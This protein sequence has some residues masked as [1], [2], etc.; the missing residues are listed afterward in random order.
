MPTPTDILSNMKE[1][2]GIAGSAMATG[3]S[4]GEPEVTGELRGAGIAF[5][6]LI[7]ATGEAVANTQRQ[8]NDTSAATATAL[9]QNKVDVIAVQ[10]KIFDDAGTL[11]EVQ[12]HTRKLPLVNFIDPV[13]YEW[14][15]VRLQGT[16]YAREFTSE[17]GSS[18]SSSASSTTSGG[19]G[20]FSIEFGGISK[21]IAAAAL[22]KLAGGSGSSSS[23]PSSSGSSSQSASASSDISMG[24][25][26]LNA[27]L[28]PRRDVGVPRPNQAIQGPRLAV[29]EGAIVDVA[30]PPHVRTLNVLIEYR[31]RDGSPIEGKAISIDTHGVPWTF[32][33]AAQVETDEEGRVEIQLRREFLDPDAVTTP[34]DVVVETHIGMVSNSTTVTF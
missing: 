23:D 14:S 34:I 31:R 26:R 11:T 21:G 7:R 17:S 22:G 12:T 20:G 3:T 27:L 10:E 9:A 1:K 4:R 2:L 33:D 16:F 18:S 24:T 5:G 32:V 25:M 28:R 13:F 8:L 6:D 30:G 15:S 29:I 19:G